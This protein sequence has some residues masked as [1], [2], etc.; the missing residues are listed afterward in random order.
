[1]G[2]TFRGSPTPCHHARDKTDTDVQVPRKINEHAGSIPGRQYFLERTY[3]HCQD[4]LHVEHARNSDFVNR[5]VLAHAGE[6][7]KSGRVERLGCDGGV[8]VRVTNELNE[9]GE[10]CRWT[11]LDVDGVFDQ[12][13]DI[14]LYLDGQT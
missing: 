1:M 9:C 8:C 11:R 12:R 14:T 13:L 6:S 4:T 3:R 7:R 10:R 2:S 5:S